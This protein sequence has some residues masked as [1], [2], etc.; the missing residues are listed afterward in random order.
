MC[1]ALWDRLWK[2]HRGYLKKVHPME[3]LKSRDVSKAN[4]RAQPEGLPPENPDAFRFPEGE[5][6]PDITQGFSTICQTLE[7]QGHSSQ[8]TVWKKFGKA[9]VRSVHCTDR[10]P[11][12]V[13]DDK[14]LH[15]DHRPL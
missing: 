10:K 12:S 11:K 2:S 8:G 15:V 7:V 4:P 1:E 6:F 5:L 9:A 3:N 13:S 14:S